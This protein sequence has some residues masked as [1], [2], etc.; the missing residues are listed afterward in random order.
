MPKHSKRHAHIHRCGLERGL[1]YNTQFN[2]PT[3]YLTSID[4][5]AFSR[6]V[7]RS[8]T[9]SFRLAY[10]H[11]CVAPPGVSNFIQ[12]SPI[13]SLLPNLL[14]CRERA[15]PTTFS[16]ALGLL[17]SKPDLCLHPQ[18][19]NGSPELALCIKTRHKQTTK[20]AP[21]LRTHPYLHK[22]MP[23]PRKGT[24]CHLCLFQP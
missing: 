2:F 14:T 15:P 7:V 17:F 4:P 10:V 9:H 22:H 13:F 6:P 3:S 18:Q 19:A 24:P 1:T 16:S 21:V 11:Y 5:V 20:L 23:S 8:S 12:V